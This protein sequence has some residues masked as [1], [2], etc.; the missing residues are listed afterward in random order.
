MS[1]D[2]KVKDGA[3]SGNYIGE[4]VTV[5]GSENPNTEW[6]SMDLDSAAEIKR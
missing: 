1:N 4:V 2:Y 5:T 6:I 3:T